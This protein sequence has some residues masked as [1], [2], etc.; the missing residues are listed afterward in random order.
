[1]LIQAT[2]KSWD[3]KLDACK[4]EK[5]RNALM[6]RSGKQTAARR[7]DM[8]T[9]KEFFRP[10]V[11]AFIIWGEDGDDYRYDNAEEAIEHGKKLRKQ[12]EEEMKTLQ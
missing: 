8:K 6:L 5:E 2:S 3:K 11:G 10:A 7:V 9:M 1:M 4:T 12:L